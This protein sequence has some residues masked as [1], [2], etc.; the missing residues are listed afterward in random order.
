MSS[1]TRHRNGVLTNSQH[2]TRSQ[3]VTMTSPNPHNTRYSLHH[4]S[5]NNNNNNNGNGSI[6]NNSPVIHKAS[7]V[8]HKAVPATSPTSHQNALGITNGNYVKSSVNSCKKYTPLTVSLPNGSHTR[9]SVESNDNSTDSFQTNN[10]MVS[11]QPRFNGLVQISAPAVTSTSPCSTS[12][13]A[14]AASASSSLQSYKSTN[15]HAIN[16]SLTANNNSTSKNEVS[17]NSSHPQSQQ[18]VPD[19]LLQ[20]FEKPTQIYRYIA[21]RRKLRSAPIFLQRN[22]SYMRIRNSKKSSTSN[23]KNNKR[24]DRVA[25]KLQNE[26][27]LRRRRNIGPITLKLYAFED[28]YN[29]N[30]N[31]S[32]SNLNGKNCNTVVLAQINLVSKF[33]GK[34]DQ[35]T[36][37][38]NNVE[39]PYINPSSN[40]PSVS[41]RVATRNAASLVTISKDNFATYDLSYLRSYLTINVRV[42]SCPKNNV[43]YLSPNTRSSS[44]GSSLSP[45][46]SEAKKRKRST[47]FSPSSSNGISPASSPKKDNSV[48]TVYTA[49]LPLSD[50]NN[51]FLHPG[52]YELP[53]CK[54]SNRNSYPSNSNSNLNSSSTLN[55][56]QKS[57]HNN[58][59]GN[60]NENFD[61]EAKLHFDCFIGKSN[62][63]SP[64]QSPMANKTQVSKSR[65]GNF[66]KNSTLSSCG[67]EVN[68][69]NEV[70]LNMKR[71]NVKI[72]YRFF[73]NQTDFQQSSTNLVCPWCSVSCSMLKQLAA[74][75]KNCHERFNFRVRSESK[76]DSNVLEAIVD[77]VPNDSY[78]GSYSG[79]PYELSFSSTT[80]FAFS[81]KG[82][83]RRN[84][85]TT[86]LVNKRGKKFIDS[87]KKD[88][89]EDLYDAEVDTCRPTVYGHDRLYYHSNTCLPIRP[90]D[91]DEDS[92]NETDPEWMRKKTQQVTLLYF[93]EKIIT[94]SFFFLV[95]DD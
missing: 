40:G 49:Q 74:H 30:S 8:N 71:P 68:T 17:S 94:F 11:P 81:A 18:H 16:D 38:A 29:N 85:T 59:I 14:T 35:E 75:L 2:K 52:N 61:L 13:T 31:N 80:G 7:I 64:Q 63:R 82:P 20:Q 62:S 36:L 24:I 44:N 79:N 83:I 42:V 67:N 4:N 45:R 37:I 91:M 92:E 90:Q 1:T 46:N 32:N 33:E 54:V 76:P 25:T 78:D 22:L 41:A 84:P 27:E 65:N 43:T 72:I 39:L 93:L 60:N 95:T 9:N 10:S 70:G 77:V 28:R 66:C 15:G 56:V 73:L 21:S 48:T 26:L 50:N 12:A 58:N 87:N 5:R 47:A 88:S 89:Y 53:M 6:C 55:G 57:S 3:D 69:Q 19:N 23:S 51:L 34:A 86:V